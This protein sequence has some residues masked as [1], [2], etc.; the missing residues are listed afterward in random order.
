MNFATSRDDSSS[1]IS[2]TNPPT[3]MLPDLEDQIS[4]TQFS[5]DMGGDTA[6]GRTDEEKEEKV[7]RHTVHAFGQARE[8]E[9]LDF[10]AISKFLL[11]SPH[12][13]SKQVY[14]G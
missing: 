4:S 13:E 11:N 2:S 12:I 14:Q 7:G 10:G 6:E 5:G 9:S 3:R 1:R 8:M